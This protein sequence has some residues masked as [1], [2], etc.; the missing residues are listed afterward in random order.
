MHHC[1]T[2]ALLG[3]I[4]FIFFPNHFLKMFY[5]SFRFFGISAESAN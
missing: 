2:S 4:A 1:F 3:Y 5:G